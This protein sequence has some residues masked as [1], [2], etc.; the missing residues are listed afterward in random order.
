MSSEFRELTGFRGEKIVE[1]CLTDY[2]AFQKLLFRPGF[3]GDKWPAVDFYVELR[4]VPGKRLYF[5]IQTKATA[6]KLTPPSKNLS[7]STKKQDIEHLLQIPGPT[8]LFGVHEP[9]KRVFVRSVHTGIPVK[10]ITR[11]PLTHELT[12]SNLQ[13]LHHEVCHYWSTTLHKPT[14]SVFA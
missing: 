4:E 13:K 5:F 3:L 8:Y 1:L 11:I 2:Q 12:S 7:I 6:S 14:F 10:A 9:S